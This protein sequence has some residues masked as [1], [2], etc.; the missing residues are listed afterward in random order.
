[1]RIL[2]V[3]NKWDKLHLELPPADR[4]PFTTFRFP[5]KDAA[6]GRDWHLNEEVQIVYRTRSPKREVLGIAIITGWVPKHV[7]T[8]SNSEAIA[9]GFPGGFVA[10]VAWLAMEHRMSQKEILD[11]PINKLTL[12]WIA[13]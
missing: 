9:D 6:K 10:M 4:P 8:I 13:R 12:K 2:P 7:V 11:M 5:R 1:M 3:A